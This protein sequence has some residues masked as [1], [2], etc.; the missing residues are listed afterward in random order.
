M[1]AV[2]EHPADQKRL[3]ARPRVSRQDG[4]TAI[5]ARYT[6]MMPVIE[7]I[8]PDLRSKGLDQQQCCWHVRYRFCDLS[9]EIAVYAGIEAE[10]RAQA[11][12]PTH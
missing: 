4:P 1:A 3:F 6:R 5:I 11:V 10:A 7:D 12:C 8:R 2:E 9:A